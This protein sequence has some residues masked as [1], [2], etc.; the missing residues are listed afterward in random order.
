[1]HIKDSDGEIIQAHIYDNNTKPKLQLFVVLEI[2]IFFI[3]FIK[4]YPVNLFFFLYPNQTRC[5][6]VRGYNIVND[7]AY[8]SAKNYIY[9]NQNENLKMYV[10]YQIYRLKSHIKLASTT[11]A[12]YIQLAPAITALVT[13]RKYLG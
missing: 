2:T 3:I 11:P 12:L 4:Q 13:Q 9:L 5:G 1:M 10:R 8:G 7:I 6:M